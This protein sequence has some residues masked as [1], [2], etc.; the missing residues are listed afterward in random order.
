MI[1]KWRKKPVTVEAVQLKEDNIYEVMSFMDT[2]GKLDTQ[3]AQ[4]KFGDYV[5]SVKMKGGLFVDTLEGKMKAD[6]GDYI[7]KGVKGEFYPCKPDI[8]H[9]TYSRDCVWDE[10]I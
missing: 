5:E 6:F 4:D 3:I 1:Q 7:I 2:V 8:F 10:N 9:L